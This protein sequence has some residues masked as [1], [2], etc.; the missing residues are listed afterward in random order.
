[1]KLHTVVL[2]ALLGSASASVAIP[3]NHPVTKGA[4]TIK[5]VPQPQAP[6]SDPDYSGGDGVWIY[7]FDANP[8]IANLKITASVKLLDGSVVIRSAEIKNKAF[9]QQRVYLRTGAV[10]SV[11]GVSITEIPVLSATDF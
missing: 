4:L 1:M 10:E 3:L 5:A 7:V 8:Y 11:L 2:F 9:F 6:L